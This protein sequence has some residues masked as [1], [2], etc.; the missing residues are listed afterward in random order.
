MEEWKREGKKQET[1][2]KRID[3][4]SNM[5]IVILNVNAIIDTH[6]HSLTVSWAIYVR[7]EVTMVLRYGLTRGSYFRMI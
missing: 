2:Y 4:N 5:S 6:S 7:E 3:I 1:K